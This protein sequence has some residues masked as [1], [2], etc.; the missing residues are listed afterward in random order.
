MSERACAAY[1]E[2]A[3]ARDS[4]FDRRLL[5]LA[6]R[7]RRPFGSRLRRAGELVALTASLQPESDALSSAALREAADDL[8]SPLLRRGFAPELVAR[9]FALISHAVR[10][11]HGTQSIQVHYM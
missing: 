6:A 2:R 4:A 5:A 11:S 3:D 7:V 10:R 1:A 8:R 9:A